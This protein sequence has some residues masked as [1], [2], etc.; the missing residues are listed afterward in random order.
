MLRKK[1]MKIDKNGALDPPQDLDEYSIQQSHFT[2][3][4]REK[5][6]LFWK[7]LKYARVRVLVE[8]FLEISE[9]ELYIFCTDHRLQNHM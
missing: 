6:T 4:R 3:V 7:P 2:V 5:D 8:F 1:T 9:I